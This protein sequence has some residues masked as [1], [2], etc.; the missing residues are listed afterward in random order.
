MYMECNGGIFGME[1]RLRITKFVRNGKYLYFL[2][3]YVSILGRIN[4]LDGAIDYFLNTTKKIV[5]KPAYYFQ[6]FVKHEQ[7]YIIENSG[8]YIYR[9]DSDKKIFNEVFYDEK[10]TEKSETC[11]GVIDGE[12]PCW[13]LRDGRCIKWNV[14]KNTLTTEQLDLEHIAWACGDDTNLWLLNF[15]CDTLYHKYFKEEVLTKCADF[16]SVNNLLCSNTSIPVHGMCMN[17]GCVYIHD[18]SRIYGFDVL[19]KD[20]KLIYESKEKDNGARIL[21]IA[22]KIIIL[23]FYGNEIKVVSIEGDLLEVHKAPINTKNNYDGYSVFGQFYVDDECIAVAAAEE[24][25]VLLFDRNKME[26][27]WLNI[28]S[29]YNEVKKIYHEVAYMEKVLNETS[30]YNLNCFLEGISN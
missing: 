6:L 1:N 23:P 19:R 4:M 12:E 17:A 13:V 10:N 8:K 16:S 27:K 15:D 28:T 14:D 9:Y 18:A 2:T 29:D 25:K 30:E 22:D 11:A 21:P 7:I 5:D 24:N 3:E 26:F 20:I